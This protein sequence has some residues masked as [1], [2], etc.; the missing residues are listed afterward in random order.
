[1]AERNGNV[2]PFKREQMFF[3]GD[4]GRGELVIFW[5]TRFVTKSSTCFFIHLAISFPWLIWELMNS[6]NKW[7]LKTSR[8][9]TLMV[10]LEGKDGNI[11]IRCIFHKGFYLL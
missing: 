9:K 2:K 7:H 4:K 8:K 5:K 1:M 11:Y 6:R 3:S 10:L